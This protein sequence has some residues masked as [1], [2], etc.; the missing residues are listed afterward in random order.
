MIATVATRLTS[1]FAVLIGTMPPISV[2][3]TVP[4]DS[5]LIAPTMNSVCFAD[6]P[7]SAAAHNALSAAD[8]YDNLGMA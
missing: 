3:R 2:Q 8:Y 5:L 4:R 7:C 1:F 6:A